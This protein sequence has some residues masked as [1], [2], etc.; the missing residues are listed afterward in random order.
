MS[1]RSIRR[2]SVSAMAAFCATVFLFML[3]LLMSG[4]GELVSQTENYGSINLSSTPAHEKPSDQNDQKEMEQ[5]EPEPMENFTPPTPELQME[6]Q[7]PATNIEL[8]EVDF[9]IK[10]SMSANMN[11]PSLSSIPSLSAPA[12]LAGGGSLSIGE[13]DNV[14]A[15]LFAPDPRHPQEAKRRGIKSTITAEL[16]VNAQGHV[17]AVKIINGK[18]K[19]VFENSIRK[20]LLRWRFKPG[21]KDGKPVAWRAIVPFKFT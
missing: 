1:P 20:A 10:T 7:A 12:A 9:T 21:T 13:L 16:Y 15:Q 2:N 18:H 4:L 3:P 19:E 5:V 8:P 17:T 11:L 14:P 6:M